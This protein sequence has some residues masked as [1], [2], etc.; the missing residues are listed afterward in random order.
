MLAQARFVVRADQILDARAQSLRDADVIEQPASEAVRRLTCHH[1]KNVLS[2][3]H[4]MATRAGKPTGFTRLAFAYWGHGYATE[5]ARAA[6][7]FGF[8]EAG[9]EEIVSFTVPDNRRSVAVPWPVWA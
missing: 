7:A 8:A 2:P 6:I 9:L 4:G 5:A 3:G 1:Q